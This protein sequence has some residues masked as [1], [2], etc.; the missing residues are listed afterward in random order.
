MRKEEEDE[1]RNEG[2]AA[3]DG[4]GPSSNDGARV[5]C[6]RQNKTGKTLDISL[7]PELDAL[8]RRL[9]GAVPTIGRRLICTRQGKPYT[10]SGLTSMLTRAIVKANKVRLLSGRTSIASFGFRDL[11]GKG[12][13]EIY[14]KQRW[15]EAVQPNQIKIGEK[16][17]SN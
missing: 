7:T 15:C 10:Y 5:L 12:A 4:L 8:L 6:V 14:V 16:P 1:R 3:G 2:S 13:T 17:A 9:V 11:K